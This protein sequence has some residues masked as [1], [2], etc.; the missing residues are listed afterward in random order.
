MQAQLNVKGLKWKDLGKISLKK[1]HKVKPA[2]MIF[3]KIDDKEIEK[4]EEQYGS[5]EKS[6]PLNLKVA[7]ILEAEPVEDSDK[8]IKM[9]IDL[10]SEKRQIVAGIKE[11]YKAKE[12][13]G[14]NIVVVTNLKPAKLK[15]IES[16][17]MLLAAGDDARLLSTPK[18][19]PGDKV[20][21]EGLENSEKQITIQ[22]FS[23]VRLVTKDKKVEHDGSFLKTEKEEVSVEAE[24]NQK[25]K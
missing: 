22:E 3:K 17:G 7:K 8:L 9:Q 25:V 16:N 19:S 5:K 1:G 11:F 12:L 4:F 2:D 15:G 21:I 6:F 14:R 20:F 24:N 13:V 18:S 10:K 23:K